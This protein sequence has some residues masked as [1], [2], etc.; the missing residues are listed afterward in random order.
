MDAYEDVMDLHMLER[1]YENDAHMAATKV[2]SDLLS[3]ESNLQPLST[4]D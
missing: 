1:Y 4:L 2:K 3:L